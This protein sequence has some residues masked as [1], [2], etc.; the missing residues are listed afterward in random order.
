MIT[1]TNEG[2]LDEA[3]AGIN[4][5]SEPSWPCLTFIGQHKNIFP[6]E[7]RGVPVLKV[8]RTEIGEEAGLIFYRQ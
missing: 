2:R 6:Q 5:Y 1:C 4:V 8:V 7:L 3:L